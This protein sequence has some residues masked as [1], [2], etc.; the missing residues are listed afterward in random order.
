MTNKTTVDLTAELISE[1][2]IN[3]HSTELT[4][5]D[6]QA[7]VY[8]LI[9]NGEVVYVGRSGN[10]MTRIGSHISERKKSFDSYMIYE[11]PQYECDSLEP[12][13]ILKFQ[14][15]YNR[16]LP[17]NDMFVT[18]NWIKGAT[19]MHKTTMTNKIHD[20][21]FKPTHLH[22]LTYY[23]VEVMSLFTEEASSEV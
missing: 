13:Y 19:G 20:A 14:P 23:D 1:E 2:Y 10:C 17:K 3:L 8:F 21:G 12:L 6:P 18:P 15:V 5:E 22:H 11:A 9:R 4:T 7:G 16:T